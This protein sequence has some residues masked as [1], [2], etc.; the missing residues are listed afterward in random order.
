MNGEIG[1][2]MRTAG[3]VAQVIFEIIRGLIGILFTLAIFAGIMAL[4]TM[5]FYGTS[6]QQVHVPRVKGLTLAEAERALTERGL[7]LKPS[8]KEYHATIPADH[9][10]RTKPYEGKRV[11]R[12]R[13]VE[14]VISMGSREVRVPSVTGLNLELAEQKLRNAGLMIDDIRRQAGDQ[15]RDRVIKQDPAPGTAVA[16][17]K[18]VVLVVSGG[19]DFG[20]LEV[21]DG[22][23]W[24]FRRIR[25]IV[26]KGPA[27][28]RVHAVVITDDGDERPAYDRVHR[29]GDEVRVNIA[30]RSGWRVRVELMGK[31]ILSK[32]F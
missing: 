30:V 9:V 17:N 13:S 20:K 27:L 24:Y 5:T 32:T 28:Q 1:A 22:P 19:P 18:G 3:A 31:E 23:D 21:A 25:L 6:P 8:G 16:R 10:I 2:H 14:C 15:P 12:G 29:P 4:A 11:K 26:P 7:K